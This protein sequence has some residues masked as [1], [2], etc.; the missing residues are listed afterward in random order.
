M[1]LKYIRQQRNKKWVLCI[2]TKEFKYQKTYDTLEEAL[3][4]RKI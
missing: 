3:K 4:N 2:N 1:D